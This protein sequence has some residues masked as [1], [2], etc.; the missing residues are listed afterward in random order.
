[1]WSLYSRHR[2]VRKAEDF[3]RMQPLHA[4]KPEKPYVRGKLVVG[5]MWADQQML[6]CG[7]YFCVEPCG[8]RGEGGLFGIMATHFI[9]VT[10]Y[11]CC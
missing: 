4:W 6:V 9:S 1:M 8:E 5:V 7:S 11:M 10:R 2:S 3:G